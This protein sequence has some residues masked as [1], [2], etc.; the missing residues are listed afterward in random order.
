VEGAVAD[1][2]RVDRGLEF[3]PLA[4]AQVGIGELAGLC[5]HVT[6]GDDDGVVTAL[7][8]L[9]D[10]LGEETGTAESDRDLLFSGPSLKP[11]GIGD[12]AR[13]SR[14]ALVV[15]CS[16]IVC[17]RGAGGSYVDRWSV[18]LPVVVLRRDRHSESELTRRVLADVTTRGDLEGIDPVG[19][20]VLIC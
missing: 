13:R 8:N 7:L 14:I 20:E 2:H 15:R 5:A 12:I 4:S 16:R 6:I 17:D 18:D 3:V 9:I 11:G 19:T 10:L 1:A